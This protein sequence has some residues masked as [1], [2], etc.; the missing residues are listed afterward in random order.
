MEFGPL[1]MPMI[2]EFHENPDIF[3]FLISTLAGGTGLNLT[4][5]NKVVIFGEVIRANVYIMYEWTN[6]FAS[7][8]NW[9]KYEFLLQ[10]RPNASSDPAHDLQAMDR[11][12][13]F[14]QT[15]DVSVFRLLGAGS[16]EELIYARQLYKQQQ[17]T[18]GYDASIQTRFDFSKI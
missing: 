15:R 16:V 2:D 3:I 10:N 11:A 6:G 1:G 7:D 17:M 4:G 9:S 14:G 8:P 13:R 18:I 12:Y 5:A